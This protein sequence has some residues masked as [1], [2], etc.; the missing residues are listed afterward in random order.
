[1]S[2]GGAK[3]TVGLLV[4]ACEGRRVNETERFYLKTYW[5]LVYENA[6]LIGW[7]VYEPAE[8]VNKKVYYMFRR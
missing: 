1:M 6:I 7:F 8:P 3:K 4:R 2:V 5:W